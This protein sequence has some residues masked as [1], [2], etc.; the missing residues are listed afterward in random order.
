MKRDSINGMQSEIYDPDV[1]GVVNKA[2]GVRVV[3]DF[4]GD[5]VAGDVVVKDGKMYVAV[6]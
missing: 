3:D 6:E 5:A 4:P 1:D 2:D